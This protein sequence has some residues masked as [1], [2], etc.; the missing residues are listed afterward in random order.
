[1]IKVSET[2]YEAIKNFLNFSPS[3]AEHMENKENPHEVTKEQVG[4]GNVTNDRQA[5]ETALNSHAGNTSNPHS[6]TKSQVGLGNV[7]NDKQATKSEYDAHVRGTADK[8]SGN[9]VMYSPTKSVNAKIDEL[10]I[11]GGGGTMYHDELQ[12]RAQS[13]AHP[14]SAITGLA[15]ELDKIE[16]AIGEVLV[17]EGVTTNAT[18]TELQLNGSSE[19]VDSG[20]Y[21]KLP[22]KTAA[23]LDVSITGVALEGDS[24]ANDCGGLWSGRALCYRWADKTKVTLHAL[25]CARINVDETDTAAE[26]KMVSNDTIIQVTGLAD[27]T[28]YW[29][30]EVKI[31]NVLEI[32]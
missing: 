13:N 12:N 14:I 21:I 10:V 3:V 8:H 24:I 26:L 32:E 4:L 28:M 9:V 25:S 1:M 2:L 19:Y 20:K 17:F 5:T 16:E 22:L 31:S 27:T 23:T 15:A 6:V 11:T 18:P 29:R 30:A 7:T